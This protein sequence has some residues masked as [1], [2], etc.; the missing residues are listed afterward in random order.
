[1]TVLFYLVSIA[2]PHFM[3][4]PTMT[5]R[6]DGR[7]PNE[8]R[9]LQQ[10]TS[11]LTRVDASSEFSFGPVRV[12]SSV[13]GP[14]EVRQREEKLDSATLAVNVSPLRGLSDLTHKAASQSLSMVVGPLLNLHLHPRSL[15]QISLQTAGL[16]STKYSKP[17]TTF[18]AFSNGLSKE[19]GEDD[20][21]EEEEEA[22]AMEYPSCVHQ[23][24]LLNAAVLSCFESGLSMKGTAAAVGVARSNDGTWLL[25]PSPEE[26]RDASLC[27]VLAFAFGVPF[28]GPEGQLV[29]CETVK[30]KTG[31]DQDSVCPF[32]P[33]SVSH[34]TYLCFFC[35]LNVAI[36]QGRA[37][38]K[39]ILAFFR[40]S[41]A[42]KYGVEQP[43]N[44][45]TA[46]DLA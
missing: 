43:G 39:T 41:L 2:I 6:A 46:M 25:D 22:E 27:L 7:Q 5:L 3:L 21:K 16:P 42:S 33:S 28:G 40:S 9:P 13:T 32:N 18:S 10:S 12:I 26:E 23:A 44:T 24:A 14:E 34:L 36:E 35:Q 20:E 11:P 8:L 38:S 1:M 30:A 45:N 17:F 31:F 37:A 15:V 29:W 4:H 19:N